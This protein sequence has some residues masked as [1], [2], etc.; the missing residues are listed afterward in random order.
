[1][2][3]LEEAVNLIKVLLNNDPDEMIIDEYG[4]PGWPLISEWRHHAKALIEEIENEK[5]T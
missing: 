4:R 2:T 1:M 5:S 3:K